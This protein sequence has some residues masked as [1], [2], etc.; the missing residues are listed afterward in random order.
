MQRLVA[1]IPCRLHLIRISGVLA[2]N[3]K[4]RAQM[5]PARQCASGYSALARRSAI[6]AG[7]PARPQSPM[8]LLVRRSFS[9]RRVGPQTVHERPHR[10]RFARLLKCLLTPHTSRCSALYAARRVNM[11]RNPASFSASARYSGS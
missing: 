3:L 11:N 7:A 1:P 2:F 4:L 9:R 6:H 10:L 5:V 8:K